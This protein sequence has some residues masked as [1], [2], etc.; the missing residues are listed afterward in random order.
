MRVTNK[1][2][3]RIA[4][5]RMAEIAEILSMGHMRLC[6]HHAQ[7]DAARETEKVLDD[8]A[9]S[10]KANVTL[11]KT[12]TAENERGELWREKTTSEEMRV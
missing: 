2:D 9:P 1:E 10:G 3:R 7:N 6:K 8:V 4:S 12:E 5:R 11:W